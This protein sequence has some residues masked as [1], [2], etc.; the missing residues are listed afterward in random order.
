MMETWKLYAIAAAIFA[1]LTSIIAKA[2]LQT[3]GADV[4][5][6]LRTLFVCGFVLLNTLLFNG[7]AKTV[8]LLGEADAR[9]VWL[10]LFSALTTA[11]SWICYYRAMALGT[12]S[13]VSLVDKGSILITLTLSVLLLGEPLTL[14]MA[15]GGVLVFAGL[16]VLVGG[17]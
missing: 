16:V 5:L 2:G 9:S 15:I 4:G 10:L 14:R 6:T 8:R 3:L 12:V 13:Y 11:L 17:K 1:G 7:V